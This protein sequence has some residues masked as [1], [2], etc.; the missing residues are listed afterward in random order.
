MQNDEESCSRSEPFYTFQIAFKTEI[1]KFTLVEGG[2]RRDM[3]LFKNRIEKGKDK[4]QL[5]PRLDGSRDLPASYSM[6][7]SSPVCNHIRRSFVSRPV[8]ILL[9]GRCGILESGKSAAV[10]VQNIAYDRV[11]F[12]FHC[13]CQLAL[14]RRGWIRT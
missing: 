8:T 5:H 6:S 4:R 3:F 10:A 11:L 7:I 1:N 14:S 2:Y 9:G 12:D 13:T